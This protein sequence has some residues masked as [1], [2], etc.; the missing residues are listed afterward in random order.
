M[1]ITVHTENDAK[2]I[3][4]DWPHVP[5]TGDFVTWR[6]SHNSETFRVERVDYKTDKSGALVSAVVHLTL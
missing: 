3:E 2:G 6:Y 1:K 5:G 4:V